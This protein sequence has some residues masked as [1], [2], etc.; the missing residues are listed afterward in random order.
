MACRLCGGA[1][2]DH[3]GPC[4]LRR[5]EAIDTAVAGSLRIPVAVHRNG[6]RTAATHDP[7]GLDQ[8]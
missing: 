4:Q 6:T 2:R 3:D 5:I 1:L 7:Y 8:V